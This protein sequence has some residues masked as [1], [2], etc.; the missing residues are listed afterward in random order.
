MAAGTQRLR[1]R[2]GAAA[3]TSQRTNIPPGHCT[4]NDLLSSVASHAQSLSLPL[5]GKVYLSNF[6]NEAKHYLLAAL[7]L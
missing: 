7:V 2:K 1:L 6:L 3:H 4:M 5:M